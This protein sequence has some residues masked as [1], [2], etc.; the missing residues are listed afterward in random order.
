MATTC[1]DGFG[2]QKTTTNDMGAT[3]RTLSYQ[4]DADGNRTRLT[5]ANGVYFTS[6]YDGLDRLVSMSWTTTSTTPFLEISYDQQGRRSRTGRG[7]SQTLYT[8]DPVSRLGSD[9]QVFSSGTSGVTTT[10]GY[11]PASQITLKTRSNT[12]YAFTG[13]VDVSRSYATNGLNQYVS[14]GP[15][16]FTYDANGNLTGDGTSSY[17]YDVENRMVAKNADTTLSY[18]QALSKGQFLNVYLK[19]A[20]PYLRVAQPLASNLTRPRE[21]NSAS[22]DENGSA[23]RLSLRKVD[24]RHTH[25]PLPN[26]RSPGNFC[27]S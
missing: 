21:S 3:P 26:A 9:T 23:S 13:Y 16:T 22:I 24:P 12:A 4:Y 6:V 15:A 10:Y 14:A 19:N 7:S 1:Y 17:A 27:A 2:R 8:Y 18:V 11:N 25:E 5:H 20:Y